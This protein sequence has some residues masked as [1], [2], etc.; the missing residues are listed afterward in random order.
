MIAKCNRPFNDSEFIK[1]CMLAV[2]NEICP[3]KK[4]QFEDI[5]LSARTCV[6][7]TEELGTNLIFKLKEKVSKFDCFSIA[8]DESTDVCDTAQLL[9]FIR[10]IDFNF[11]ISEDLAELCSLK[12]TTTG[13]DLF[14]E[15]DKTFK[16]HLSWNK[17]V[18]VTTDGGRNMSGINK[19]LIGRINAEMVEERHEAPMI[20]HCIIHQ[21]ALCC[22]VL[23]WK[24]VMNIV[25]STVNYIRKN[26]LAHRQFKIFLEE[27]DA[28]YGDVIYFSEVRWLS[29]GVVLKRFFILRNE[30][31]IFMSEKGKIVPELSNEKWVLNLAFLT[32]I[33][34]LL[35]ELNTKLQRSKNTMPLK[36]LVTEPLT[37]FAKLLG[38]DGYL[39]SHSRNIYHK[40]AVQNGKSFLHIYNN[41]QNKI[42]N[43]LNTA[44]YEQVKENRSRLKPII[45]SLIFLGKQN[46]AI[47]GHRDDGSIFDDSQKPTE[48]NG[49]FKELLN[50][51]ISSGD[52]ILKNHLLSSESRATYISKTTQNEL[53][54]IIGNLILKNVLERVKQSKFYSVIFDETTDVSNISQ[55][56]TVIQYVHKNEVYEDF[57][58]FLDCH[59]DNYKNTG[60]EVEPKMTGEII[61]NSVLSILKKL[62]LPFENCVGITTDGCSVMLS[63]KCGAVKTLK[64]KMKN[65]IKCTCFSHALNLSIM[66]GCKIKFALDKISDWDDINTASKASY[67]SKSASTGEFILTLTTVSEIFTLTSPVSKLLQSKSQDKFS[68]T[69]IIN[70]VISIL[71]KK[72]ENSSNCFNKI[73]KTAENQMANLGISIGINKPRLSE[74]MKNRENPQTQSVEEYFRITLFIPFLDNLLYDLES[75]FD[76]D[77][78]SVFDLDVVLPNIVKT[79]SIFDDKL[80]LENKI[81]N[82]INQFGDLVACEINIPRDIFESSIIGEFELWHNYWL[83]EE[84]LPSSPLEAIKQCDPD[85]FSGINVWLKILITLPATGATAERNFS[86]LRRVKT[87][88]RSRISE[89]RLNGLALLHAHR[90]VIINHDEVIDIFAQSNR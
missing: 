4:K 55:L 39:E 8:T 50:F 77:L 47:R 18:S 9:I 21:E 76:E 11:N 30:I 83:Q 62:D 29:R 60:G 85:L 16:K 80:K 35:N 52:E 71:K 22:K 32:D 90:D 89:E 75:R 61:G 63:E 28:E 68:A 10:G 73:F 59:Q 34:T 67:L 19:G 12:G 81:K 74:V 7:R 82:V 48:N 86:S 84:Q 36:C 14:I 54:C 17:L 88:M 45:D 37:K 65:A 24:D 15:I 69:T 31:N 27:C 64:E 56:V 70:N 20:F 51:R 1:K 5:S 46:I 58:G 2:V 26:A 43:K 40:N 53:I 87:W 49:N 38:K 79:K 25:V 44:H 42:T 41:P 78:M 13:E 66:K 23:A 72:R 57:I 3:E 33:T 6:R